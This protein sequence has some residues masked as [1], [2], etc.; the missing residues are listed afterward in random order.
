MTELTKEKTPDERVS[1]QSIANIEEPVNL[2]IDLWIQTRQEFKQKVGTIMVEKIDYSVIQGKK[3]LGKAGAE[4]IASIFNWA[5]EFVK[6]DETWE[7]LGKPAGMLC[8]IC[9]LTDR[10]TGKFVGQGRGA[11]D[12]KKESDVNKAIKMATKSAH[13]DAVIRA[14]GLSDIFTQDLEDMNPA[15][16]GGG[17]E[18]LPTQHSKPR[19]PSEKQI[20]FINDLIKQTGADKAAVLERLSKEPASKVI[21]WLMGKQEEPETLPTIEV[22]AEL[23]INE[24]EI[25]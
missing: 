24:D 23:G 10:K 5:A 14:S 3:S 15:D 11:R 1:N 16:I 6:D 20:K 13:I 12:A 7:M 21:D 9:V 18:Y 2:D 25:V 22:A 19:P 17:R 4:K 8:Y